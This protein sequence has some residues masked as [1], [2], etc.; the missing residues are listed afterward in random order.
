MNPDEEIRDEDLIRAHLRGSPDAF[1]RL[2]EH[3]APGLVSLLERTVK[4]H[5]LALDLTQDVFIKLH[6]MLPRYV[7]KG[8]FRSM[9]YAMTLNQARDALRSKKR[10]PIVYLEDPGLRHARAP[11]S[12]QGSADDQRERIEEAL[13]RVPQPFREALYLRE[14]TGLAYQEMAKVLDCSLGTVKSRVSRGRL[15]FRDLYRG[16]ARDTA[17]KNKGDNHAS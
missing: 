10:S 6:A 8:R 3:H 1:Q 2:V 9:L 17:Q 15:A 16:S 5:H 7:F 11:G 4:D 14:V 13:D 12:D